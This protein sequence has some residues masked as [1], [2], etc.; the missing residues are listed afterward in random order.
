M[1]RIY[2]RI[3]NTNICYTC[4]P[5]SRCIFYFSKRSLSIR[6]FGQDGSY[7]SLHAVHIDDVTVRIDSLT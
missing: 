5:I 6:R 4:P 7:F 3:W 2:S 1:I